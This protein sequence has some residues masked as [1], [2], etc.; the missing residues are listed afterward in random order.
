VRIHVG[1]GGRSAGGVGHEPTVAVGHRITDQLDM[2]PCPSVRT[3]G[4]ADTL[5]GYA[6][7]S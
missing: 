5:A 4:T 6:G 1:L 3:V 7:P 2:A